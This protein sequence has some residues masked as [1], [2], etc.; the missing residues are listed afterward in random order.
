MLTHI[1]LKIN[2]KL[3]LSRGYTLFLLHILHY[4]ACVR[5]NNVYPA[6][7]SCKIFEKNN[8]YPRYRIILHAKKCR[9]NSDFA[10]KIQDI[11]RDFACKMSRKN[12]V[13]PRYRM[14]PSSADKQ[15]FC[16]CFCTALGPLVSAC[17]PLA[18]SSVA[19]VLRTSVASQSNC[20]R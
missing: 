15:V 7:F 5:K 6:H 11:L 10:C 8:V 9:K 17:A 14:Y 20:K 13:Y 4:A 18:V 1:E 3:N 16:W 19:T 2:L 12:N